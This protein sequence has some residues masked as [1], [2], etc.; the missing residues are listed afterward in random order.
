LWAEN[1]IQ[2]FFRKIKKGLKS[3]FRGFYKN[4]KGAEKLQLWAEKLIQSFFRKIKKGLKSSF[5]AF[6]EKR[7]RD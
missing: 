1:L 2:S 4:K 6:L 7:K 3:S 5:R